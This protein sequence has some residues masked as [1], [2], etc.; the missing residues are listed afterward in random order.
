MTKDTETGWIE[1]QACPLCGRDITKPD[2]PFDPE[3]I[4]CEECGLLSVEVIK[5]DRSM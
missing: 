2:L 4:E 5:R 1:P 3:L